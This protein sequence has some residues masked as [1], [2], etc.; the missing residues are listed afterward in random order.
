MSDAVF[1]EG[2]LV[3]L[4]PLAATDA[5]PA[6]LS[7]LNDA[8]VLRYRGPKAFPSTMENLQRYVAEIP[9]RG[10]LVLAV[11]EKSGGRHVGNIALN[12]VNWLHRSAELS[13]MIG[14]RDTWGKGYGKEAM[15][16][17]TRHGFLNMGLNRLWAESPNP[18]FNAAVQRLGWT[19]EGTKRQAFLLD[20]AYVDF[21]CWSLLASE[22]SSPPS[23]TP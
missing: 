15:S 3:N 16:L 17:V 14:A 18:A 22:F 11:C 10:D 20:G 9:G 1:I 7:W 2:Q 6:Y 4:R 19:R 8:A 13:I 23:T 21:E 5:T 12:S